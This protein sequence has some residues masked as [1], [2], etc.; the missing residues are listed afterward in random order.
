MHALQQHNSPADYYAHNHPPP[1]S[2]ASLR[3]AQSWFPPSDRPSS[4]PGRAYLN[5]NRNSVVDD[6]DLYE[7]EDGLDHEEYLD[8]NNSNANYYSN[9]LRDDLPSSSALDSSPQ[10]KEIARLRGELKLL[11]DKH[12]ALQSALREA[13]TQVRTKDILL[14][15]LR[16]RNRTLD[17]ENAEL[18]R[19]AE[20]R[21]L[22]VRSME[23]FLTKTDRWAGSDLV[24]AVKD[25]NSEI[26]QF[27]AAASEAMQPPTNST[28]TAVGSR[29][30]TPSP[31]PVPGTSRR[32]ALERVAARFGSKMRQC[33]E[34]RDHSQDPTLLQ[35]ALQACICQCISHAMSAFCFGSTGKLESHLSK[36]YSHMH[37]SE[38]QPTSSRWRA[39][40][41]AHIR[42]LSPNID[43]LATT[44]VTDT[45]LRGVANVLSASGLGEIDDLLTR[46][47]QK[48]RTQLKRISELA[49]RFAYIIR[50][51]TMST[52]FQ[53]LFVE[54]VR[55]FNGVTME[56]VYEGYGPS[57]GRV[58]C[59]TEIGLQCLTNKGKEGREFSPQTVERRVV[60]KPRVVLESIVQVLDR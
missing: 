4:V 26:L 38:P 9:S 17:A 34:K 36:I 39:L 30:N 40:T 41:H 35:Y 50:E 33:L 3:S 58:L 55:E 47:T 2:R 29:R 44:E 11:R 42:S 27:A 57:R 45:C 54:S 52:D 16:E 7:D 22:E 10:A 6:R 31:S 49:N 21:K 14:E 48:Y 32:K 15:Q 5:T 23:R 53:P 19:V 13:T 20:E 37:A 25:I 1:P 43:N 46:S 18:R 60:L 12:Y 24:Q 51:G 8:N 56:N 28:T 59:T